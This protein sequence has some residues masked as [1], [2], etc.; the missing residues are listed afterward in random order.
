MYVHV[1]FKDKT[2]VRLVK[3]TYLHWDW[4]QKVYAW[5]LISTVPADGPVGARIY[6]DTMVIILPSLRGIGNGI[7]AV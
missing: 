7:Q 2:V 6:V 4:P 5:H 1:H 3:T